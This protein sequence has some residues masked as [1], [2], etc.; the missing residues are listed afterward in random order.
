MFHRLFLIQILV[1]S[2]VTLQ[3]AQDSSSDLRV[4]FLGGAPGSH[5]PAAR[6]RQ[7]IPAL[8]PRG[9]RVTYTEEVDWLRKERLA[10]FDCLLLYA[11][12]DT[13]TPSQEQALLEFVAGGKGF[14]PLHCASF[15]F[16][17]SSAFVELVGAQFKSHRTGVFSTRCT[18]P[19]HPIMATGPL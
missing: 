3:A 6:A 2:T 9:I 12:I 14:V 16:R 5:Q 19:D 10:E 1:V 7:L 11:N 17:N 18:K 15:C 13:I 8:N 4:L